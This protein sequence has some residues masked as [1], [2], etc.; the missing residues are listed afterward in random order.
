[1][2]SVR[3]LLRSTLNRPQ[4]LENSTLDSGVTVAHVVALIVWI[5]H[6]QCIVFTAV[7]VRAHVCH[8]GPRNDTQVEV[9]VVRSVAMRLNLL[10]GTMSLTVC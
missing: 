1:M 10:C 2:P 4:A 3:N 5:L 9:Y 8:R 6:A 7:T